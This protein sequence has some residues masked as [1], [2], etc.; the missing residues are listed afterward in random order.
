M[1][2]RALALVLL[3]GIGG[4]VLAVGNAER[5]TA[6]LAF[7]MALIAAALVG[8]LFERLHLPRLTGY[9]A[10][11]VACGPFAA[12]LISAPMARELQIVNGLAIA[13]I[14]FVA[15]LEINVARLRPKL[16]AFV[17]FGAV[18]IGTVFLLL[19]VAAWTA[20][21]WLPIL[22]AAQGGLRVA[23][24]RAAGH[25]GHQLLAD[26][27]DRRARRRSAAAP[28][29]AGGGAGR[30]RRPCDHRRL[31]RGD[32]AGPWAIGDGGTEMNLV[33]RL[34]WDIGG[35]LACG[36][37]LG[38][39]FALFLKL[40]ARE[41]TLAL[42]GCAPSR[43]RAGPPS[44]SNRC[45]WRWP[46][47]SCR[48]RGGA[49][50]GRA[51]RRRRTRCAAGAG[52]LLHRR[53][54]S[55]Q[56]DALASS[57][58]AAAVSVTRFVAIRIGAR[59]GLRASGLPAQPAGD[60]WMGLVSQAGVTLGMTVAVASA[61]ADWGARVQTLMVALIA[62]HETVGPCSSGGRSPGRRIGR[63]LR[64]D[65]RESVPPRRASARGREYE[66]G[67]F[68]RRRR[69]SPPHAPAHVTRARRRHRRR[70]S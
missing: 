38:G 13:L 23:L 7:G 14:A 55:L 9:L 61:F 42:P 50:R 44:T 67:R 63:P 58:N 70:P 2:R 10:F 59:L 20:W 16:P 25:A 3:L 24:A 64:E 62:I 48:E 39:V 1:M 47:G 22:P 57:G 6:A 51:A 69:P 31:H 46:P 12:N 35:S 53:R 49:G 52:R 30:P 28:E 11:G 21:P 54:A 33:A 15:G 40:V 32:A 68:H 34:A 18:L 43:R 65:Q 60:A 45:W 27:D 41:V 26:G 8:D 36:A 5:P 17:R 66:Q 56:L 29:R 19:F 4:A 37:L